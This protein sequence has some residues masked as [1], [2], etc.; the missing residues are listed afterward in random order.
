MIMSKE[1]SIRNYKPKS[2]FAEFF[3]SFYGLSLS[4]FSNFFYDLMNKNK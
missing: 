2:F 4:F 1:N 3:Y